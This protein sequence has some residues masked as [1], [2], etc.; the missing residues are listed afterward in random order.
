MI[1]VSDTSPIT[2]LLRIGRIGLLRD[3]F[4]TV[5]IPQAVYREVAFLE[6]QRIAIAEFDWI[7]TMPVKNI[8]LVDQLL[9]TLDRGEAEAIALSVELSAKV[10]L[11]DEAAGRNEA[12]RLG[13]EVTGLLGV[14]IR[15]KEKGLIPK[16]E[17]EIQKLLTDARFWLSEELIQ[18]VLTKIGEK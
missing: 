6:D 14:L 10:L 4:E 1:V 3:L 16:V 18:A 15:A 9:L 13:L 17:P 12:E 7:R 8:R 5:I 11:I 2:N